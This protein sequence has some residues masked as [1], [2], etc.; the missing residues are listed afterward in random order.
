[1]V[2]PLMK[3]KV[4][5]SGSHCRSLLRPPSVVNGASSEPST[6]ISQISPLATKAILSAPPMAVSDGAVGVSVGAGGASV[7]VASTIT[8]GISVEL[9]TDSDVSVI[10]GADVNVLDGASVTSGLLIARKRKIPAPAAMTI[11][12]MIAMNGL[13][14]FFRAITVG[15]EAG[16]LIGGLGL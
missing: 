4:L 2:F 10:D 7:A 11:T 14:R 16:A 13:K 9:F 3:I 15:L 1:M 8:T 6:F 5:P 12:G